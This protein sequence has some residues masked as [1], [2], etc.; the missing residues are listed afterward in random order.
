MQAL[1]EVA[2]GAETSRRAAWAH[3]GSRRRQALSEQAALFGTVDDRKSWQRSSRELARTSDP[4]TSK[5]AAESLGG[6]VGTVRRRLAVE[7]LSQPL[8][9]EEAAGR[10]HIDPWQASKRTSDLI[11]L[12][13][14]EPT[15]G[16]RTGVSG[17]QQ[18]VLRLTAV[19]RAALR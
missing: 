3:Y 5:A 18:R 17:R 6:E 13:I 9:S 10:A 7:F 12:G 1:V 11:R 4:E 19:G 16:T 2:Q 15:G 8:T 14:I